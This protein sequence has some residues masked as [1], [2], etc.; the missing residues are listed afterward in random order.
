MSLQGQLVKA[1]LIECSRDPGHCTAPWL[2]EPVETCF[3]S[4]IGI[5]VHG[6]GCTHGWTYMENT[7]G[8]PKGSDSEEALSSFGYGHLPEGSWRNIAVAFATTALQIAEEVPEGPGMVL[9]LDMLMN[10][11][12][13]ILTLTNKEGS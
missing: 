8:R 12:R 4:N 9:G 7:N 10:V 6:P 1:H 13:Y 5:R 2:H 3:V 11:Q